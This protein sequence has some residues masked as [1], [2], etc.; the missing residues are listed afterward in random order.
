MT[1]TARAPIDEGSQLKGEEE[2]ISRS[3][4]RVMMMAGTALALKK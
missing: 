1:V 2:N 4:G 3:A